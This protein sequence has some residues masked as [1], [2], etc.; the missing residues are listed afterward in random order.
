MRE[1]WFGAKGSQTMFSVHAYGEDCKNEHRHE[2]RLLAQVV[3]GG[4]AGLFFRTG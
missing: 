1:L 2:R 4:D 3:I